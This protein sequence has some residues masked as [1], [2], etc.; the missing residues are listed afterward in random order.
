MVFLL[1][2][3]LAGIMFFQFNRYQHSVWLTQAN[4]VTGK[5]LEWESDLIAYIGLNSRNTELTQLNIDLQNENDLLRHLVQEQMA[6]TTDTTELGER[7]RLS[8]ENV[9]VI[10]ASVVS[11]S[12]NR[13]EN[14][15]TINRGSLDGVRPEMGV[16][17]GT[18]VV[19]I[20]A[21]TSPHYAVVMSVLNKRSSI[22][23][24]L[25][26]SEYFGYMKWKGGTPLQAYI[27]DIPRHATFNV[28]DEVET[29]GFSSVFPPGIYVGKV[30]AIKDSDDGLS[31][32]LEVALSTDIAH[33][34]D[35]CVVIPPHKEELDS[36]TVKPNSL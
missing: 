25:R 28:G 30:A 7:I 2:E 31:Y 12:V 17:S 21:K 22:S 23:C 26:G 24:R 29:S 36:M 35:V 9:T 10:P 3:A 8:L 6:D 20:V 18:G 5:V 14:Y 34:R 33:L 13:D 4:T 16:L 27:E 11:N 15:L 32:K 19:G 1:L